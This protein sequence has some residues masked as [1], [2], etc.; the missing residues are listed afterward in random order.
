LPISLGNIYGLDFGL[1][2]S[3]VGKLRSVDFPLNK[4][5]FSDPPRV[6]SAYWPR[7]PAANQVLAF[8]ES[9]ALRFLSRQACL[10]KKC[11]QTFRTA[12]VLKDVIL[13]FSLLIESENEPVCL[14]PA[15]LK[16]P[17]G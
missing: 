7:R 17:P 12:N 5:V 3:G 1:T 16:F 15:L 9:G 14:D 2:R 10:E 13:V 4:G 8:R 11:R 6:A